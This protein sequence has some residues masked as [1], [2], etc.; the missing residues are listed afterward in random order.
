MGETK[1][2]KVSFSF[3]FNF[4]LGRSFDVTYKGHQVTPVSKKMGQ[5]TVVYYYCALS[6]FFLKQTLFLFIFE[7]IRGPCNNVHRLETRSMSS[8]AGNLSP[9]MFFP[10]LRQLDFYDHLL[11]YTTSTQCC[12]SGL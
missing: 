8:L 9:I 5:S 3:N 11:M 1:L 4:Q 10:T 6:R 2:F 7:Q 12:W